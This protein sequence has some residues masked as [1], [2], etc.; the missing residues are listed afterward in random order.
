MGSCLEVVGGCQE[1]VGRLSRGC[2]E[3]V[4]EVCGCCLEGVERLSGVCGEAVRRM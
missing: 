3:A 1:G 2:A 4:R